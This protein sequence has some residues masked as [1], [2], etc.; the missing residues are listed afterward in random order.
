MRVFVVGVEDRVRVV[1][2]AAR[3]VAVPQPES[4]ADLVHALLQ[5]TLEER[6]LVGLVAVVFRAQPV[7]RD[8]GAALRRCV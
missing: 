6:V 4:V 5:Q 2:R 8:D 3:V 7:Q 1:H